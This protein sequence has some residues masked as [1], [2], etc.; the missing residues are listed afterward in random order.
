MLEDEPIVNPVPEIDVANVCEDAVS[1][2]KVN[3]LPLA[4]I[5]I[6]DIFPDA[7]ELKTD[8]PEAGEVAGQ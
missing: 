2:F 4:D 3:P 8:V 6:Q 7:F 1:P 5:A